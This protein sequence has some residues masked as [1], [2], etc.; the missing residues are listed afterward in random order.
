MW[1]NA[2]FAAMIG[3]LRSHNQDRDAARQA[4]VYGLALY[5]MHASIA[6]VLAYLDQIDPDAAA[7]ARVRYGCLTPWQKDPAT[8][9]RAVLDD[10]YRTC[11]QEVVRQCSDLL[12]RQVDYA[13]AGAD[14]ERFLDAAQS[15]RLVAAAERYYRTMYYGGADSWNLRDTHMF[16]TL[17]HLLDAHGAQSKAVVWA[18]NSHVGDARHTDMGSARGELNIGQ[19]CRERFGADACLVGFGTHGGTVA[20]AH[21][22]DAPMEVMD[23]RPSHRNSLERLCH[24]NAPPRA[25]LDLRESADAAVHRALRAA[26]L[27]RFIGVIYRPHTELQSHYAEVS[28]S[29]Q[30]DAYVWFDQTHAV[31]ALPAQG[32]GWDR[33][34][35]DTYPF[36]T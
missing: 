3:W 34:V 18:H 29:R 23:V 5:N 10:R 36:A 11:E 1:Q 12:A 21:D 25:L 4:G 2:E 19:L 15:A 26:H 20:A 13:R 22:W 31:T 33:D 24:D 17:C 27:E 6:T 8:Y 7:T 9:G 16:D 28:P 32:E 30:F 14:G 35:P